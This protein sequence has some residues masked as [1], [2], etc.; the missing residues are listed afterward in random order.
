MRPTQPTIFEEMQTEVDKIDLK[1]IEPQDY[2]FIKDRGF[3]NQL[4]LGEA[5]AHHNCNLLF[6]Y[7]FA[8]GVQAERDRLIDEL[9]D[10]IEEVKE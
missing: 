4:S 6:D 8:L 3:C 1:G 10:F 2:D 9:K 5:E 7:A